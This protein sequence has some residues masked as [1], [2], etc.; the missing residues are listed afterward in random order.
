[1][2][3]VPAKSISL[4]YQLVRAVLPGEGGVIPSWG[5]YTESDRNPSTE[6]QLLLYYSVEFWANCE[7]RPDSML[8]DLGDTVAW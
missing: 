8:T 4:H 2:I 5:N 1:M 6:T 7:T 3:I